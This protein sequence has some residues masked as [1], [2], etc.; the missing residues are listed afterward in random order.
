MA[1]LIN[2]KRAGVNT[3]GT[4]TVGPEFDFLDRDVTGAL[5]MQASYPG[6]QQDFDQ[7]NQFMTQPA[8]KP[9]LNL[10]SD[11]GRLVLMLSIIPAVK[12]RSSSPIEQL[13]GN[14]VGD[15]LS[16]LGR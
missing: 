7:M 13:T 16:L 5:N 1:G 12:S 4:N 11:L 15:I 8:Q 3:S 6:A 2:E 14:S 10:N 9:K